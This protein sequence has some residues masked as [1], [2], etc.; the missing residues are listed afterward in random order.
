MDIDA[1]VTVRLLLV[2]LLMYGVAQAY[3]LTVTALQCFL[4]TRLLSLILSICLLYSFYL[5]VNYRCYLENRRERERER[6]REKEIRDAF[7]I[8]QQLRQLNRFYK[9][10]LIHLVN[11][12]R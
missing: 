5:S 12:T 1:I 8:R 2:Q 3:L 9:L 7:N 10:L 4:L 11:C 6:E